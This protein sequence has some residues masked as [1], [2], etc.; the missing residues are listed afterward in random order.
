M[1]TTGAIFVYLYL[2]FV[3]RVHSRQ[4]GLRQSVPAPKCLAP[5]CPRPDKMIL[6]S[7][8]LSVPDISQN[9]NQQQKSRAT[10]AVIIT[11]TPYKEELETS[12]SSKSTR[13]AKVKTHI[14]FNT[15]KKRSA[16]KDLCDQNMPSTSGLRGN[17][18]QQTSLN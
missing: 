12:Q 7:D 8:N 13:V 18:R 1:L 16:K 9:I 15:A 10:K 2:F 5:N 11:S 3:V 17:A 4:D 14:K 6:P